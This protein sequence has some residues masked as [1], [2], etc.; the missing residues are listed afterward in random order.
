MVYTVT[1]NPSLDYVL[2]VENFREG[3]L[4]RSK[5][6]TFRPG[7]KGINV[8][9]MLSRLGIETLALGFAGG[10]T[11]SE[12]R[13][14]LT[15]ENVRHE[16]IECDG[17]TRINVKFGDTEINAGGVKVGQ[18]EIDA[19]FR[20]LERI[21]SGDVLVLAGSVGS[22]ESR[23]LYAD[24]LRR[25]EG[26]NVKTVVD[27]SGELLKNA[28]AKRPFLVKPNIAEL[29]ELCGVKIV[30]DDM[31]VKCAREL[32]ERGAQNVIVSLGR[33]GALLTDGKTT[34]RHAAPE[35]KA[36]CAVGAGDSLVA[37][38]IAGLLSGENK[39]RALL[40]G[41]AAGSATA[42]SEWL[43]ERADVENLLKSPEGV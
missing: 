33:D 20:M 32:I 17:T 4:N 25:L 15:E 10:F 23:T 38:F 42:F 2:D 11:G 19:L 5:G 22:S 3:K 43:A 8:S 7:G 31:L 34:I 29:E 18:R 6:E 30:G 16:L 21:K 36:V 37:G 12:L 13:R 26:R 41:I 14:R 40:R 35:G 1:P 24:I 39:E 27:A 9:V 28:L